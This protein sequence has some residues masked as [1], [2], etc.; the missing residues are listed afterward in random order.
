MRKVIQS[1]SG[2]Q[3]FIIDNEGFIEEVF[4]SKTK[5]DIYVNKLNRVT[6]KMNK[7]NKNKSLEV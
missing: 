1:E 4:Y 7:A 3:Y 2:N 6:V 5:A